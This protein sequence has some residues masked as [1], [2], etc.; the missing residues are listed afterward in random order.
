MSN[1]ALS[2]VVALRIGVASRALPDTS[3]AQLIKVLEDTVGLPPT[4]DQLATLSLKQLLKAAGGAL[5]EVEF[6]YLQQ[7]L[8]AL[9]GKYDH[10]VAAAAAVEPYQ[11]GDMPGSIR[12]AMA[13]NGGELLNGHFGS[14]RSFLIYQLS[15]EALRLIEIRSAVNPSTG[16]EK[17]SL[18]AQQLADC[19]LLYVVSVGGPAAAKVVN[20]GILPVKLPQGGVSRDILQTLQQRLQSSPPPWLAKVLGA[21]AQQRVRFER[22]AP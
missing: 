9:Q 19:Q 12:V 15:G 13:S 7:A 22:A 2:D 16:E 21:T 14:C 1:R 20:Q 3:P 10:T 17:N 8:E 18:R 4:L 11:E 6:E 5:A